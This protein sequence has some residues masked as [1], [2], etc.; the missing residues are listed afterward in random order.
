MAETGHDI[1]PRVC[2]TLVHEPPRVANV[3][4]CEE[5]HDDAVGLDHRALVQLAEPDQRM[6]RQLVHTALLQYSPQRADVVALVGEPLGRSRLGHSVRRRWRRRLNGLPPPLDL[7]DERLQ[8]GHARCVPIEGSGDHHTQR[9]HREEV[10][11]TM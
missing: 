7:L 6:H 1:A 9:V 5:L 11:T 8:L 4:V 10:Q 2:G 3:R